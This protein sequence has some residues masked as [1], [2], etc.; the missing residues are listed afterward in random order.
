L[1][2]LYGLV[3]ALIAL[4]IGAGLLSLW[5][6]G[7]SAAYAFVTSRCKT[8]TA[9]SLTALSLVLIAILRRFRYRRLALALT[10][11]PTAIGLGT[12]FQYVSGIN[13][14]IDELLFDDVWTSE[15]AR[16]PNRMSPS[17]AL[18]FVLLGAATYLVTRKSANWVRAGQ[19]VAVLVLCLCAF[20]VV[21]YL[22]S[23][24]ALYQPTQFIRISPYTAV[25]DGFLAFAILSVRADLGIAR[26]AASPSIGGFLARR[27]L[28][29]TLIVP[30][31]NGWLFLGAVE[32]GY[33]SPGVG[34]ALHATSVVAIMSAM[35]LFLARSLD[36]LERKR[37]RAERFLRSSGELTA[38][39]ARAR[40][41]DEVV[42]VTMDVG[43]VALGATAGAFLK[44][45]ADGKELSTI[46]TRGY[47]NEALKGFARIDV[48]AEFP[49][50]V[51]V[52]EREAIFLSSNEE[53]TKR[54]P[55]MPV[56][57]AYSAWASLPLEGNS[58]VLGAIALSFP[59]P[60][61]FDQDTRERLI[62]LAWQCAQALDRALLFDSEQR[63][64]EQ[65]EAASRAKDE[66][67]A[68]L[69]HELRNPL[70]PI[71]TSLHLMELRSPDHAVREREVIKR[72]VNHM[73]RLV[74]DLL[75][76]SRIANGRVELRKRRVDVKEVIANALEVTSPLIEQRK[77]RVE[78]HFSEEPLVVDAD[79]ARLAQVVS[80]LLT[81]AA[82]YS[83]EG[84][85]IEVRAERD[86]SDVSVRVVDG[87]VGISAE[88]L[89]HV[90]ELFVQ[91]RRTIERSEGGLGLGL[92]LVRSLVGLH[93]GSVL[94]ESEG[95]GKG[96]SFSFRLPLAAADE[97]AEPA[98]PVEPAP[99][100]RK[101]QRV[102]VVD[103][104]RD[105]ADALAEALEHS[106]HDVRVAYDG[107]AALLA[108]AEFRPRLALLDLGLPDLDGYEVARRLRE[109]R[110]HEALVLVAVT[111]YGQD[112]DRRRS[113]QAGFD[114]HLVKPVSVA[115]VLELASSGPG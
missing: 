45:S 12:L 70:S 74:D 94:A 101:S 98:P 91:G 104:N 28:P 68:M 97:P 86:G 41:V 100:S 49:V 95:L 35:V 10:A 46:A 99:T 92:S 67:L 2:E 65:A 5:V 32:S 8:N 61:S 54:F 83:N 81:N 34:H 13:L 71:L 76:V 80:N 4:A 82:K 88:L 59:T 87:G 3:A 109:S 47:S 90:F 113:A 48:A 44:L 14:G 20:A 18:Q 19:S 105:A 24:V 115:D 66:F 26:A 50:S 85:L 30:I 38:A 111:G 64:R 106:G 55:K 17:A 103:D 33:V 110:E 15:S 84:S 73:V 29:L 72:Q 37:D 69:G 7:N 6:S 1:A 40:T 93:G 114:R 62:R 56:A 22:Y 79:P 39:L 112:A 108:A 23:I 57:S 89:P 53:R 63:A 16:F 52:R 77:H 25:A 42:A 43:L 51:A 60:E 78:R 21:G 9:L 102:L 27:L 11:L 96:S 107:P 58:G 36:A 31:V 75:D